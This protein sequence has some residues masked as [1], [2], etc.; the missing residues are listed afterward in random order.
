[1]V[2]EAIEKWIEAEIET[3]HLMKLFERIKLWMKKVDG[4]EWQHHSESNFE[5]KNPLF[6]M[7]VRRV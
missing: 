2:M 7:K 5:G 1:M 4:R 6:E 3:P